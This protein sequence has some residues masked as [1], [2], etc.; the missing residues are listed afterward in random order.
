MSTNQIQDFA[1]SCVK[2]YA[3]YSEIDGFYT[4]DVSQIS[5]FS[6]NYFAALMMQDRVTANEACGSDNRNFDKTMLPSLINLLKDSPCQH[7]QKDFMEAWVNG[8]T[9]YFKLDMQLLIDDALELY[10]MDHAA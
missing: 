6:L 4:L 1:K 5:D 3:T 9:D 7:N 2:N 10:N 8:V